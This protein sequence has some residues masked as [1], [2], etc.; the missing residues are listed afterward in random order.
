MLVLAHN[1][2]VEAI[3][4]K[5]GDITRTFP[6]FLGARSREDITCISFCMEDVVLTEM[7]GFTRGDVAEL[8]EGSHRFTKVFSV[9]TGGHITNIIE[10]PLDI[11]SIAAATTA[12]ELIGLSDEE[13]FTVPALL[14]RV[15]KQEGG[16]ND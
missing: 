11:M 14:P 5:E 12:R 13:N 16:R 9:H 10:S 8:P 6:I 15:P 3:S 7:Q 4:I 1:A 2:A